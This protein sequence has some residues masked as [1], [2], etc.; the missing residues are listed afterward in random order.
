MELPTYLLFLLN[1]ILVQMYERGRRKQLRAHKV[2]VLLLMFYFCFLQLFHK[3]SD[4]STFF[5]AS[6]SDAWNIYSLSIKLFFL[7]IIKDG[8]IFLYMHINM[9]FMLIMSPKLYL[10]LWYHKWTWNWS[11]NGAAC[12][13]FFSVFYFIHLP[14]LLRYSHWICNT[15]KA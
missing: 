2:Y 13:H 4:S 14:W 9:Y 10:Q 5:Q 6:F 12:Q 11:R 3:F 1:S 15:S 8:K 7:S